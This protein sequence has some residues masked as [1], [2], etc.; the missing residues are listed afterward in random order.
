MNILKKLKMFENLVKML[1]KITWL[2]LHE[3]WIN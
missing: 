3:N 1:N 2:K